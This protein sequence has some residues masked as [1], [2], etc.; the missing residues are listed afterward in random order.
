MKQHKL[1]QHQ[2]SFVSTGGPRGPKAGDQTGLPHPPTLG[3]QNNVSVDELY[4]VPFLR[5]QVGVFTLLSHK[6]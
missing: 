4:A 6:N 2:T 3:V 1:K 5:N